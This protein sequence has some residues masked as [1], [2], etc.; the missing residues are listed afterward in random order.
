MMDCTLRLPLA[1]RVTSMDPLTNIEK[2]SN[3]R[4]T[5]EWRNV[6]A[7]DVRADDD[8][9]VDAKRA[10]RFPDCCSCCMQFAQYVEVIYIYNIYII[11]AR[12][13]S[14]ILRFVIY[15]QPL[16]RGRGSARTSHRPLGRTASRLH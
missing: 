1:M 8:I 3:A 2:V 15:V 16:S 11:V 13:A 7:D 14:I 10:I 9:V 12:E 4:V 6:G 5:A